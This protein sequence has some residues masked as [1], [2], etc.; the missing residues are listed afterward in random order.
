[1]GG[2]WALA[3]RVSAG[4]VRVQVSGALVVHDQPVPD[5]VMLVTP[6]GAGSLNPS[7]TANGPVAVSGPRLPTVRVQ[8]PVAP[9]MGCVP[10]CLVRTMSAEA[11]CAA[12][13]AAGPL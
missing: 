5:A 2:N 13:A 4:L 8:L 9:A 10:T 11:I 3:A 7:V 1:M 12:A 6:A